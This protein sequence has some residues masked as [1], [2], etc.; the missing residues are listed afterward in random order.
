MRTGFLVSSAM[1]TESSNPTKAKKP[2]AVAPSTLVISAN[3]VP[4]ASNSPSREGSP[5]PD[6]TAYA[7]I[8]MITSRP[9]SST[10]V[11]TTLAFTDSETP[12]RFSAA[13]ARTKATA[14]SDGGTSAN[15]A[16]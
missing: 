1:F 9:L 6:S 11:R 14:T 7:P 10:S 16:M 8:P 3:P 2:S 13:S 12:R 15:S 4:P 5:P